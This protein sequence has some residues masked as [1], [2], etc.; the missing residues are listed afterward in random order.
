MRYVTYIT[1]SLL[2]RVAVPGITMASARA[3]CLGVRA[4]TRHVCDQKERNLGLE[5]SV[6]KRIAVQK[7]DNLILWR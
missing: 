7:F 1:S 4:G 2:R 6:L 3:L 5:M